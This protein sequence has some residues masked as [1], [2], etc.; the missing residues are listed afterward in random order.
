MAPFQFSAEARR[1]NAVKLVELLKAKKGPLKSGGRSPAAQESCP[2]WCKLTSPC[3]LAL[4]KL[5][6]RDFRSEI[7]VF[8]W[9][10]FLVCLELG[11]PPV[12]VSQQLPDALVLWDHMAPC[13]ERTWVTTVTRIRSLPVMCVAT[14]SRE[15][16]MTVIWVS[17]CHFSRLSSNLLH[18]YAAHS[19]GKPWVWFFMFDYMNRTALSV[20]LF[21]CRYWVSQH[22]QPTT[23]PWNSIPDWILWVSSDMAPLSNNPQ[24]N[25]TSS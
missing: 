18:D 24:I 2:K 10:L 25:C 22:C 9:V 14:P 13:I 20:L 21:S 12:Q 15:F 1:P 7:L 8:A 4:G 6:P 19:H 3:S 16:I 5:I 23:H 11:M 17:S